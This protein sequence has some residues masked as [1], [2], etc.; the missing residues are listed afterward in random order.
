MQSYKLYHRNKITVMNYL[1]LSFVKN[2]LIDQT[3]INTLLNLFCRPT[4]QMRKIYIHNKTLNFSKTFHSLQEDVKHA[5][6]A[7]YF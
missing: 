2:L 4:F 6:F 5:D 3:L 1:L 7:T